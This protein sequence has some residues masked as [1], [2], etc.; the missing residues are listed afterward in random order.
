MF[1][2]SL[3]ANATPLVSRSYRL[4]IQMKSLAIF[5]GC[6]ATFIGVTCGGIVVF[7]LA[8]AEPTTEELLSPK[9]ARRA[10]IE[11]NFS[12]WDGSHTNLVNE[13]KT[14]LHDPGSFEHVKTRY[15]DKS[16]EIVVVMSYRAKNAFGALVLNEVAART[17]STGEVLEVSSS[18][19][20]IVQWLENPS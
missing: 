16:R 7:I 14:T 11:Q 13:I 18:A 12:E 17:T 8:T 20:Q 9:D 10:L 4:R 3:I 2:E 6:A 5:L 19:E 1:T 15:V